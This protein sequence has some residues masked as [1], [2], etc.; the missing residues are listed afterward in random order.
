LFKPRREKESRGGE[1]RGERKG[2]KTDSFLERGRAREEGRRVLELC[3][4]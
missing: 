1:K 4:V 2:R 3:K